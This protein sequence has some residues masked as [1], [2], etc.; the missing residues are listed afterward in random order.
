MDVTTDC[1]RLFIVLL[2]THSYHGGLG[3]VRPLMTTLVLVISLVTF[4]RTRLRSK[5][6]DL[7][8]LLWMQFSPL[9]WSGQLSSASTIKRLGMCLP[10]SCIAS[11]SKKTRMGGFSSL[12]SSSPSSP[13][14]SASVRHLRF[15]FLFCSFLSG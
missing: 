10:V 6:H 3:R 5:F 2:C 11:I 8:V 15:L 9:K 4:S 12:S 1:A 13:I 7:Q 14:S